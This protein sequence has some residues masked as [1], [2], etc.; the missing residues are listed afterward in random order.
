MP[1]RPTEGC[2]G[3]GAPAPS[4]CARHIEGVKGRIRNIFPLPDLIG[5]MWVVGDNSM[6]Q[7][8]IRLFLYIVI[9]FLSVTLFILI[10]FGIC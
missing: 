9:A 3:T 10:P 5:I 7:K 1:A 4:G 2:R 6:Q 8:N